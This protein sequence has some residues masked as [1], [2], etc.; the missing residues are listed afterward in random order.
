MSNL[1][2]LVIPN[3]T[4]DDLTLLGKCNNFHS[5]TELD[6][7]GCVNLTAR[8]LNGL[9]K[10]VTLKI[11]S[12]VFLDVRY[13]CLCNL[14]LLECLDVSFVGM[15]D[16]KLFRLLS[17]LPNLKTVLHCGE[18]L[19]DLVPQILRRYLNVEMSRLHE[20][21]S[22]HPLF[23]YCDSA[24]FRTKVLLAKNGLE[25]RPYSVTLC[26]SLISLVYELQYS[27]LTIMNKASDRWS[28][29]W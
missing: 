23:L 19:G 18:A 15:R 24:I 5:L 25:L 10:L 26:P 6:L 29:M 11:L 13:D 12:V 21:T 8:G 9:T 1:K 16:I 2:A 14:T 3:S 4:I 22:R 27:R 7:G 28:R 20:R 17:Q